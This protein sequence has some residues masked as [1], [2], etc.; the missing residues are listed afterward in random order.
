MQTGGAPLPLRHNR[1]KRPS[2]GDNPRRY[3]VTQVN[4][5]T[6]PRNLPKISQTRYFTIVRDESGLDLLQK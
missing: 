6:A 4:R 2:T 5:Q 1:R 3:D